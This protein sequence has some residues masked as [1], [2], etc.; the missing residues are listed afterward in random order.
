MNTRY[1]FK[2][3]IIT[4]S[5]IFVDDFIDH[6]DLCIDCFYDHISV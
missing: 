1:E 4:K 2:K 6:N 5:D 3:N